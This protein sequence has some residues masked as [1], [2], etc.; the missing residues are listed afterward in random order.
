MDCFVL[1]SHWEGFSLSVLEAMAM[2]L[3]VIMCRVS[4]AAEAV[5]EGVTG[6]IVPI[7]DRLALAVAMQKMVE[8]PEEARKFGVNGRLRF[9]QDFTMERMVKEIE[10]LYEKVVADSVVA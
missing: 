1:A 2:G 10:H 4:G 6:S 3:P 8:N 9:E 7:G 5:L